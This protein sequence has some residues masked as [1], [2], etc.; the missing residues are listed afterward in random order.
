[1]DTRAAGTVADVDLTVGAS[2][3][4]TAA[5]HAVRTS[6]QAL[7]PCGVHTGHKSAI[8]RECSLE[9]RVPHPG[10]Q[11][12]AQVLLPPEHNQHVQIPL[13]SSL[14][15]ESGDPELRMTLV[16][17]ASVGSCRKTTGCLQSFTVESSRYAWV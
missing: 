5:A 11:L 10:N 12:R 14:H 1:M 6:V 16:L 4:R 7:A 17:Y 3:S 2:E 15:E 9:Q 8:S 13:Q